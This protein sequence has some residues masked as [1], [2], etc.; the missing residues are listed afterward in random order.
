MLRVYVY[1]Y[2]PKGSWLLT[3]MTLVV[4]DACVDVVVVA[5]LVVVI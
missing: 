3:Q 5:V 1:P 4:S 2:L